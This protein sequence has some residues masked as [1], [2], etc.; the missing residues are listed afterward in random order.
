MNNIMNNSRTSAR[1]NDFSGHADNSK[2]K[3]PVTVSNKN[4]KPKTHRLKIHGDH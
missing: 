4:K 3:K 1:D 2:K